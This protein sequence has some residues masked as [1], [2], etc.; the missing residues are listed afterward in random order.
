MPR[1]V[2]TE[3]HTCLTCRRW[4]SLSTLEE[5]VEKC[6]SLSFS[7]CVFVCPQRQWCLRVWWWSRSYFSCR[8][9]SVFKLPVVCQ[10]NLKTTCVVTNEMHALMPWM[11]EHV[12]VLVLRST[13]VILKPCMHA[14]AIW[15]HAFRHSVEWEL[16]DWELSCA[17]LKQ[18]PRGRWQL[19]QTLH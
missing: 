12:C 19:T 9:V 1:S 18:T 13:E 7:L 2:I 8:C 11:R 15:I 10:Y 14:D 17:M 16:L 5:I 3:Q 4:W 6:F